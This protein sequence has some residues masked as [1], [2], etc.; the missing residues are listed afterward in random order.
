VTFLG[1]PQ[2]LEVARAGNE[3]VRLLTTLHGT[4]LAHRRCKRA[5]REA[6]A[7]PLEL[8]DPE[9]A[10]ESRAELSARAEEIARLRGCILRLARLQRALIELALLEGEPHAGIAERL[11]LSVGNACVLL[12]RAREHVRPRAFEELPAEGAPPAGD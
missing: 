1:L 6:K 7:A 11:G 2:A 8:A 5:R 9:L 4:H 3:A 10:A 12:H